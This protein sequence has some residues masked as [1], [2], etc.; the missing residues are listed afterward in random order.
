[1]NS[2]C[3][4][5]ANLEVKTTKEKG[6]HFLIHNTLKVRGAC[7]SSEIRIR[8]SDK[9]FNYSNRHAQTKQQVG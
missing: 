8:K 5:N 7:W 2:S 6:I 9:W 1:L 4:S 3:A